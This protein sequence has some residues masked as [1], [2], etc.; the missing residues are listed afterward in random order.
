MGLLNPLKLRICFYFVASKAKKKSLFRLF[1]ALWGWNGWKGN[2]QIMSNEMQIDLNRWQQLITSHN[3][4]TTNSYEWLWNINID[5][6]AFPTVLLI[7][8][9]FSH[10]RPWQS[11]F[12]WQFL[13]V[14][15]C[16]EALWLVWRW[17]C[18]RWTQVG[19]DGQRCKKSPLQP[20]VE[21]GYSRYSSI[22][23]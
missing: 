1:L 5:I 21:I 6:I 11:G 4:S 2:K 22:M 18:A 20:A 10:F 7:L 15:W 3:P 8:A 23:L 12:Q 14:R 17:H 13:A 16:S 9:Y 19:P